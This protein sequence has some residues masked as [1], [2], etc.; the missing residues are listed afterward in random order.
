[1]RYVHLPPSLLHDRGSI[2]AE[3]HQV[4]NVEA[5]HLDPL[6]NEL[7]CPLGRDG[8]SS[9]DQAKAYSAVCCCNANIHIPLAV[10]RAPFISN[11]S[12]LDPGS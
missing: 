2:T 8:T 5:I 6:L 9:P 12:I 1:M 11:H 4:L 3:P 7:H 10:D